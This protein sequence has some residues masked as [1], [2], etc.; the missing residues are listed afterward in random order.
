MGVLMVLAVASF[1]YAIAG[2]VTFIV[3]Y[4][5][6]E[7]YW[8]H[9]IIGRN[10]VLMLG[11]VAFWMVV[12]LVSSV[13]A[14]P[15][16]IAMCLEVAAFVAVGTVVWVQVVLILRVRRG[17]EEVRDMTEPK[18]TWPWWKRWYCR[19]WPLSKICRNH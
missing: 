2:I 1:V 15:I 17:A 16:W 19:A 6:R 5:S 14:L 10:A 3:T 11:A 18:S 9:A 8:T 7:S 12:M 4:T 13:F